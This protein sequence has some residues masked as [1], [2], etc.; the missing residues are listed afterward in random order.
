[1]ANKFNKSP[2]QQPHQVVHIIYGQ[3]QFILCVSKEE[4]HVCIMEQKFVG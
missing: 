3:R 4:N 1:M 2:G